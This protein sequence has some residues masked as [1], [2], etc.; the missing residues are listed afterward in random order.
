MVEYA[1]YALGH[2]MHMSLF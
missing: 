2:T 1:P